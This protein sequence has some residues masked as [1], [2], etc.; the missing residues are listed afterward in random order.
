MAITGR[1][2]RVKL[3]RCRPCGRENG[4]NLDD[5]DIVQRGAFVMRVRTRITYCTSTMRDVA[6]ERVVDEKSSR[7]TLSD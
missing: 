4:A 5:N 3:P 7:S 6:C 2:S 1:L